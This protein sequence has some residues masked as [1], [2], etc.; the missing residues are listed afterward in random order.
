VVRVF[1]GLRRGAAGPGGG[2]VLRA[3][4]ARRVVPCVP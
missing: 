4:P 3:H 2:A 1:R